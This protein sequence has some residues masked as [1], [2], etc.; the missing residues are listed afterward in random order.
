MAYALYI[1]RKDYPHWYRTDY[2][3]TATRGKF[4]GRKIWKDK[5]YETIEEAEAD[6]KKYDPEKYDTKIKE[7]K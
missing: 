5:R 7:V 4:K 6:A 2:E 1:K 3:T